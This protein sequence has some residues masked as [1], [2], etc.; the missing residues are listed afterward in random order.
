MNRLRAK[1]ATIA[2][3]SSSLPTIAY[4]SATAARH[5]GRPGLSAAA[6]SKRGTNSPMRSCM[7]RIGVIWA[8]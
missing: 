2:A 7:V 4:V 5:T 8:P 1:P 6:C 3:A